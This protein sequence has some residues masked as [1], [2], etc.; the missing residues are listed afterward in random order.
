MKYYLLF[1]LCILL[2]ALP[3]VSAESTSVTIKYLSGHEITLNVLNP[4][5]ESI[6]DTLVKNTDADGTAVFSLNTDSTFKL[7]AQIK[8]NGN[9][10]KTKDFGNTTYGSGGE[11]SINALDPGEKPPAS[12]TGNIVSNTNTSN[13]ATISNS[14]ASQSQTTETNSTLN[15]SLS[16]NETLSEENQNKTESKFNFSFPKIPTY[17]Y[18]IIGGIIILIILFLIGRKVLPKLKERYAQANTDKEEEEISDRKLANAER[19]MRELQKEIDML[20]NKNKVVREAEQKYLE[21]KE[22]YERA[23]KRYG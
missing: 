22:E 17:V 2:I 14:T 1:A 21:A 20:K 15:D 9:I 12:I 10:I 18:Y 3:L 23:K 16:L 8:R 7:L 13:N 6:E 19:K 5:T 11:I 4:I